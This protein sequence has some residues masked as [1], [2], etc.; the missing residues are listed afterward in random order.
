MFE[1]PA[2]PVPFQTIETLPPP[3]VPGIVQ[4]LGL[5]GFYAAM[6]TV[7]MF[8]LFLIG[9]LLPQSK[10]DHRDTYQSGAR[11]GSNLMARNALERC[12]L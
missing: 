3:A 2:D 4:S 6:L 10:L 11:L 12:H 7:V 8:P 9:A 1:S 5:G